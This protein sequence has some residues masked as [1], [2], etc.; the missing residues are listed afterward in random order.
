M[1]TETSEKARNKALLPEVEIY[2]QLLITVFLI[3]SKNY[4]EACEC[5][6][7]LVHKLESLNRRTLNPL[8]AKCYF[9]YTRAYELQGKLEDIR[10]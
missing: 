3:D 4:K 7:S 8:S 5:S 1:E 2:I 6:S 9:Y 10:V